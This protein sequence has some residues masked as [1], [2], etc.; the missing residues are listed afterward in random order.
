MPF[1]LISKAQELELR[2]KTDNFK[3]IGELLPGLRV[4]FSPDNWTFGV[5]VVVVN[6]ETKKITEYW[7]QGA[8]GNFWERIDETVM[9][10]PYLFKRPKAAFKRMAAKEH[11]RY[12]PYSD[13]T[14]SEVRLSFWWAGDEPA[15]NKY[16]QI[17]KPP[18]PGS[19]RR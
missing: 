15:L 6:K 12:Y 3:V 16:R 4:K 17:S 13:K 9:I 18:R 19:P 11:L 14:E 5:A 7:A 10:T 2:K 8:M 1:T